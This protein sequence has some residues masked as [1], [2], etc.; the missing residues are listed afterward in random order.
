MGKFL[1]KRILSAIPTILIAMGIVFI[2]MHVLPRNPI[3]DKYDMDTI[4]EEQL[5][6]LEEEYGFNKPVIVQY[7]EYM[8]KVLKGDWGKSFFSGKQVFDAIK[9][10]MEPTLLLTLFSTVITIVI[11]IPAGVI[12]ATHRNTGIDYL[13]T[14]L[15]VAFIS[16]PSFWVG[17][18]ALYIF[19][20]KLGL[21]PLEGYKSISHFGLL[22]ALHSLVLPAVASGLMHVASLARQ[23]RS[24]ML[25][26][27]H[28]DYIRT[29]R[30]K[31]LSERKVYYKHAL[32]NTMS[33][34][35]TLIGG[36]VGAMLGGS[37]VME[38]VFNIQGVGKLA[39]TSLMR[40]DYYQ[41]QAIILFIILIFAG[42]NILLDIIYKW[43]DPRIEL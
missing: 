4:T 8:G 25:N 5:R 28:Q 7:M 9:E 22:A 37:T 24:Q 35:I 43:L 6:E 32:K 10:R 12:A 38:N 19:A 36:S 21:F 23:T 13:I 33:L 1:V 16:L 42:M 18:M 26:V 2:L 34:V 41:E 39:Y 27:L 40:S 30:A 29:A 3:L 14:V 20:F 31:G 17:V 15:S 11:A